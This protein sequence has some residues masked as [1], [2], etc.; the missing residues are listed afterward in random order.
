MLARRRASQVFIDAIRA[1][2]SGPEIAV[3]ACGRLRISDERFHALGDAVDARAGACVERSTARDRQDPF[4]AI[5]VAP[6]R[7][8][9]VALLGEPDE[10]VAIE[11][12]RWRAASMQL[13]ERVPEA[14]G[15]GTVEGPELERLEDE[16]VVTAKEDAGHAERAAVAE[17][18]EPVLLG[19]DHRPHA[20][21]ARCFHEDASAVAELH[22]ACA[23][24]R[25]RV[26]RARPEASL[27]DRGE[28]H[29]ACFWRSSAKSA[30]HASR[31]IATTSSK[32]STSP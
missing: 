7:M 4:V 27:E 31:Q 5:E 32:P 19:V 11:T 9:S 12:E 18:R 2:V 30:V 14:L 28:R 3:K 10:I 6:A 29:S 20:R 16:E 25:R 26:A 24:R 1:R 21:I 23:R 8:R 17:E 22:H 13:G 15:G